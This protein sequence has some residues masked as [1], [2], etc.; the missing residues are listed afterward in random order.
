MCSTSLQMCKRIHSRVAG[1]SRGHATARVVVD[2]L[3]V[4]F[5]DRGKPTFLRSDNGG[6]FIADRVKALLTTI[7]STPFFIEP[8]KPWQNGFVESFHGR[9]R[10][11][12]MDREAF[13]SLPEARVRLEAHRR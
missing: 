4:L 12:L 9:L 1:C 3:T 11:E 13:A 5:G 2:T 8:G 10:D 7:G 6:A